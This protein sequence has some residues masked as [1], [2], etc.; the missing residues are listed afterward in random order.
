MI[1]LIPKKWGHE[2]I[3]VNNETYCSKF[4][5][6]NY[7]YQVSYHYHKIKDE[8]FYVLE[9][10]LDLLIYNDTNNQV[11]TYPLRSGESFRVKPGMIHS[12]ISKTPYAKFL[13]VSTHDAPEDSYRLTESC[14][15][16]SDGGKIKIIKP[17]G[18]L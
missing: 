6:I 11:L 3:L 16:M 10:L 4:L 13:E 15:I 5:Y 7:G 17:E 9:G 12:F 2:E 8:T 18:S 1:K 14:K